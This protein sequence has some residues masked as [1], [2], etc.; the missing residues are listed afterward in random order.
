MHFVAIR[1]APGHDQTQTT[2][3]FNCEYIDPTPRPG[4][5]SSFFRFV[6]ATSTAF[7]G[8]YFW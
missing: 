7:I 2:N 1:Y 5:Q 6:S 8:G 3:A 4:L